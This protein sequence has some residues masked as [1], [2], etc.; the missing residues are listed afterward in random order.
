MGNCLGSRQ[1]HSDTKSSHK[2]P[3]II[4]SCLELPFASQ[5]ELHPD[6]S[7]ITKQPTT[8]TTSQTLE[9]LRSHLLAQTLCTGLSC[10][11]IHT[12]VIMASA[13]SAAKKDE[14]PASNEPK[15]EQTQQKSAAALE[16]DDE[17]EDFPVD[18]TFFMFQ[19]E[20]SPATAY[21]IALPSFLL[22]LSSPSW[23]RPLQASG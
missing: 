18:G 3:H 17:F 6:H 19:R 13:Q 4:T 15:P 9:Q 1:P 16:E 22:K 21:P 10:Q 8:T 14:K 23:W 7:P 20:P 12:T 11:I 5:R 2:E